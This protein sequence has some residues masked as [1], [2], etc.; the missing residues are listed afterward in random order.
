[1][2]YL[3]HGF[4]I[5]TLHVYGEFL[6]FQA[7]TQEIPGVQRVNLASASEHVH[8]IERWIQVS[9]EIIRSI[10]NSLP[11]NKFTKLFPIHLLFQ[12]IK[13]LNHFTVK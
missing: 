12:V 6:P 10:R 2:Y 8:E 5:T 11:F 7:L 3:K 1:M 13:I 4:R 9:R